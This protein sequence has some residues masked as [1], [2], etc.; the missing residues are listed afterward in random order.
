MNQPC[1]VT[2][3]GPDNADSILLRIKAEE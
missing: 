1:H 3:S 2:K